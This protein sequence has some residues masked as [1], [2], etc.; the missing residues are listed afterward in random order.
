MWIY[1]AQT[2]AF[3][4]VNDAAVEHYGYS[5]EEFLAMQILDIRPR[6]D[7]PKFLDY[8]DRM[9]TQTHSYSGEWQHCKRD[10][11]V[12]DV[13]ITSRAIDWSGIVARCVL[14][15]DI[16]ERKRTERLLADYSQKI[17]RAHV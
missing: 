8:V 17:G 13:E 1:D 16:T 9:R 10:G 3:L 15:K 6:S 2:L 5:V 12:I 4:G 7:V 14:V 11:T